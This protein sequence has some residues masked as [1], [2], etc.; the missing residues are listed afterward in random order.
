MDCLVVIEITNSF[1]VVYNSRS[2]ALNIHDVLM[3]N[4]RKLCDICI[5]WTCLQMYYF[6]QIVNKI[7][8]LNK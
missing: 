5:Q 8:V 4:C 2:G 3:K 6:V 1:P 7:I